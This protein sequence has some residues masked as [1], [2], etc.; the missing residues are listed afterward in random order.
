MKIRPSVPWDWVTRIH[1]I[2][3]RIVKFLLTHFP[4]SC[5]C[6]TQSCAPAW[7]WGWSTIAMAQP[8]PQAEMKTSGNM[9]RHLQTFDCPVPLCWPPVLLREQSDPAQ[10]SW[11]LKIDQF[12]K[13][14]PQ[15][16]KTGFL[17]NTSINMTLDSINS[18]FT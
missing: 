8:G 16:Q 13:C 6:G 7:Q 4:A 17:V 3:F 2:L 12:P 11:H 5:G 10:T 18:N 9:L 14:R 1:N 15:S